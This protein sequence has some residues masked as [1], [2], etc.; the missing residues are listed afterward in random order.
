[1]LALTI[2]PVL[3]QDNDP[4][5]AEDDTDVDLFDEDTERTKQG[6]SRFY[7]AVGAT[8]L[9]ADG[10]FYVNLPSGESET[11]FN[12]DRAGLDETDSSYWVSINWR[13]ANSRWGAWF[14]SWQYDV[15]GTRQWE[16][17]LEIPGREP[18][19]AGAYVSSKFDSRWYIIETTYSFFRSESLDAGIGFG[20]H[21]VDLNTTLSARVEAGNGSTEAFSERLDTLAPLPNVLGYVYWKFAPRWS[22]V[23]RLG[24][25]GLDYKEHSG[26]MTNAH[27]MVH[28]DLSP[29][30]SLGVGYHFVDLD[31]T[32]QERSYSKVYSIDFD[33]PMAYARINF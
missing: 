8:Y 22:F 3:A 23:G 11:I 4:A 7:L 30:W 20:L 14:A 2:S 19:P 13:S 28:C 6:W 16:T 17:D 15:T 10:S 25:F 31:L 18:I 9:D 33:G 26:E 5:S 27:A 24:W 21:T 12:F 29:R 1:M 32:T